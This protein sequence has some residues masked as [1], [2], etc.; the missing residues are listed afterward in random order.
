MR[1]KGVGDPTGTIVLKLDGSDMKFAH[2]IDRLYYP[3]DKTRPIDLPMDRVEI[4]FADSY[5][6]DQLIHILEQF[7]DENYKHFGDWR[8]R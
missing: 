4:E 2:I 8:R 5:E 1:F 7:K 3:F 6:V